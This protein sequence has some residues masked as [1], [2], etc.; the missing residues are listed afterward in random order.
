MLTRIWMTE[1]DVERRDE[2]QSFAV[3]VSAPMFRRLDG[4]LGHIYAVQG[5][6]WVTQTF[7]TSEDDIATAESSA[8]YKDGVGQILAAGFGDHQ[9]I[10]VFE[11]TDYAP[12]DAGQ[13]GM[14]DSI[15]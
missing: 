11:V 4:C 13:R 2:L 12:P 3:E 8:L 6:T 5:S 7:W 15:T 1:F 10:T 14:T 9:T